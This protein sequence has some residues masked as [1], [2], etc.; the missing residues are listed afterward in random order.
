MSFAS[1]DK[2]QK[3]ANGT[4]TR[5]AGS[6]FTPATYPAT[7]TVDSTAKWPV[8]TDVTFAIDKI[9]LNGTEE[10]QTA[11]TYTL[12]QGKVASATT[13]TVYGLAPESPNSAQN[14]APGSL[15]RVYI[16]ISAALQNRIVEGITAQHKQ[17]G[18]H[19]P[20]TADS[21]D[22]PQGTIKESG[23]PLQTYRQE[24]L[25]NFVASGCIITQT[26]GLNW[27]MTAGVVY[28]N[29]ARYTVAAATGSVTASKD[30]YFDILAPAT[31]TAATLVNTGGNVV[32]NNAASPALAANSI[33]IGKVVSGASSITLPVVQTASDSI[34]NPIRPRGAASTANLQNPAAFRCYLTATFSS[35]GGS[36]VKVPFDTRSFDNGANLDITTNKGRFT[37]PVS[38]IYSL[39]ATIGI[40]ANGASLAHP[41]L[42]KNGS[43]ISQGQTMYITMI[44]TSSFILSVVDTLFLAAGDYIEVYY[45]CNGSV[46]L[47]NGP[48]ESV[49]SGFLVSGS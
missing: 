40:I 7:I 11:G 2:F 16:P 33:R 6:G 4:A 35:T 14:Y 28:I 47:K 15:T 41:K 48:T 44:A 18:T 49:F 31:G 5:L 10:V 37:A 22:A 38:G 30:T 25:A 36:E 24:T 27:S 20:V 13:I 23:V 39:S 45:Y 12:W 19:G 3:V 43:S 8:D 21:L 42:Y 34:G 46:N 1:P 29:G 9:T 17:D 32:A 26:S